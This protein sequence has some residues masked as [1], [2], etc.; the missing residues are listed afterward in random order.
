MLFT[1]C[2]DCETTFRVTADVLFKAAGKVRCGR[3][4]SVFVADEELASA[5]VSRMAEP[6]L[7]IGAETEFTSAGFFFVDST[8]NVSTEDPN[9]QSETHSLDDETPGVAPATTWREEPSAPADGDDPAELDDIAVE[10][11]AEDPIDEGSK[12]AADRGEAS[13]SGSEPEAAGP[14]STDPDDEWAKFFAQAPASEHA[15]D[16]ADE[17]LIATADLEKASELLDEISKPV[18]ADTPDETATDAAPTEADVDGADTSPHDEDVDDD[19]ELGT[20]LAVLAEV[21][22]E[23]EAQEPRS[24][25]WIA[26][27][28]ILAL[29]LAG[30]AT[31]FFRAELATQPIVGPALQAAYARFG[32]EII[33]RWD[34]AQYEI[35]DWVAAA[36]PSGDESG[37]MKITARIRNNGPAAQPYPNIQLQ[38]KDRW[39]Q[40]VGSRVFSP[41]EY[42]PVDHIVSGLMAAGTTIPAELDLL[43][44]IEEAYGF[45][46]DVCLDAP[47]GGIACVA[48]TVFQ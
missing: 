46:L 10:A 18:P 16:S 26:G 27:A 3:C 36:E 11:Q 41:S 45:E 9:R 19:L 2:P 14:S 21:A 39:D 42:L 44:R 32:M 24:R 22:Q 33:P 6:E 38:L 31:H 25:A 15:A 1:R 20:R 30:Q 12:P 13:D 43:D 5:I 29:L 28:A 17:L 4:D 34:L 35:L 8:G 40:T 48:D 37:T 7:E 47:S 23:P